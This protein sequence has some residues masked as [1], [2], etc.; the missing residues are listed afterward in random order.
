M[1]L[2]D[3]AMDPE[4]R[5]ADN[6]FVPGPYQNEGNRPLLGLLPANVMR[7][8]DVGCG[9]GSNARIL[10]AQGIE[11]TAITLS[12]EEARL[13][14]PFC[15]RTLVVDVEND[16]LPVTE[17][18]FDL[19]L[20]SHVLEHLARPSRTLRRLSELVR[21]GG[22]ALVAVPNMASWRPRLRM[23]RGD[24]SGDDGGFFDRT[25]LQ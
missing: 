9:A 12:N 5:L 3:V 24:L 25:H 17:Q 11:V 20:C 21:P 18:R 23:L 13:A 22:Y 1:G 7:V 2:N 19:I 8:L 10:Q 15:V 16:P 6:D 4:S 14:A